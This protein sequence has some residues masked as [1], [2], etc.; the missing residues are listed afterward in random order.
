M[1]TDVI[2][3]KQDS[4]VRRSSTPMLNDVL[5]GQPTL[6][7]EWQWHVMLRDDGR[8]ALDND[9]DLPQQIIEMD[10]CL[11]RVLANREPVTEPSRALRRTES[12]RRLTSLGV[13]LFECFKVDLGLFKEI[14]PR[15][16]PSP[17]VLLFTTVAAKRGLTRSDF[18]LDKAKKIESF[19]TDLRSAATALGIEKMANNQRRS[20]AEN[21][22]SLKEYIDSLFDSH[23]R[24]LVV[25]VDLGFKKDKEKPYEPREMNREYIQSHFNKFIKHLGRK[26][27]AL[28]GFARKLEFG[29]MRGYHFHLILFFNGRKVREDETLGHLVG[30]YWVKVTSDNGNFWNCNAS[31]ERY[32]NNGTLGI[33]MV[34]RRDA[35]RRMNLER[36]ALYLVKIDNHIRLKWPPKWRTFTKGV[37]KTNE[38]GARGRPPS[39]AKVLDEATER[40]ARPSRFVNGRLRSPRKSK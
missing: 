19:A 22:K 6:G 12:D 38:S 26:F 4:E 11:Q 10:E 14:Y 3:Q 15:H 7:Q 31:K 9:A 16:I 40:A 8:L 28:V 5:K 39:F 24:L 35:E 20:V 34:H 23:A 1:Q 18:D 21:S 29:V 36:A 37:P 25:R 32:I 30:M 17:Y 33:G 2:R 13:R 27:P